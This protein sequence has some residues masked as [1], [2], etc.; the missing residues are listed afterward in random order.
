MRVELRIENVDLATAFSTICADVTEAGG[1]A[2]LAEAV[3]AI[4]IELLAEPRSLTELG[5]VT[6]EALG[7][8]AERRNFLALT[9]RLQGRERRVDQQNEARYGQEPEQRAN[10]KDP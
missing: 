5:H 4:E 6:F 1:R 7:C 3:Q 2:L 9:S 10:R 8:V